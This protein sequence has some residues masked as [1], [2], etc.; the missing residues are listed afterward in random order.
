MK[1]E[2]KLTFFEN[3]FY[4]LYYYLPKK[5][6]YWHHPPEGLGCTFLSTLKILNTFW[7]IM[8]LSAILKNNIFTTFLG[9]ARFG[10]ILGGLAFGFF[11]I[12]NDEKNYE[13]R[14]DAIVQKGE[15][16]DKKERLKKKIIFFIYILTS[17][18]LYYFV[19]SMVESYTQST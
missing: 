10:I 2:A 9:E 8:L 7:L 19:P 12:R 13:Q 6:K 1:N 18:G 16:L 4:W 15:L 17:L 3:I 11:L 5:S 14:A